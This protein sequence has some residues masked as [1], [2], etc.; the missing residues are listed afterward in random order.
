LLRYSIA[1][2]AWVGA[3]AAWIAS[4]NASP[5]QVQPPDPAPDAAARSL[6]SIECSGCH[7][8]GLEGGQFGPEL[9]GARFL[10]RW[11]NHAAELLKYVSLQMPPNGGGSLSDSEYAGLV[12]LIL[13][14]NGVAIRG[15]G[16]PS[17]PPHASS[18]P[19][20]SSS[21]AAAE[22]TAADPFAD[23]TYLR[24]MSARAKRLA[25]IST[26][27]ARTLRAP[28][29]EDWLSWR[30]TQDAS[31]FSPLQQINKSTISGL[32]LKWAWS[33]K[34]GRNEIAPIVH[35][36]I[37][38]LNSAS[39][40]EALDAANGAFLW[41]YRRD[42]APEYRGPLNMVQRSLAIFGRNLYIATA[43]RHV[44]ALDVGSGNVVWDLEVVTPSESAGAVLSAGP[45]VADGVLVQ[46]VSLGPSCPG[47]CYVVGLDAFTGKLLWRFDTVAKAGP[48]GDTWNGA[49]SAARS[50]SA[51]WT[52]PSYDPRLGAVYV[53]TGNTY[54]ISLLLTPNPEAAATGADALFTDSTLALD[55]KTGK[56]LWYHQHFAQ[57][58]WDL[59]EVFERTL[60][61]LPVGGRPRR[62]MVSVG[63]VGIL[64]ALDRDD[65]RYVFSID[66]GLNNLVTS[67]DP[68]SG[69]RTV[70]RAKLPSKHQPVE[71]CPSV[72]GA[73]NWMATAY[74]P[75]SHILYLPM[76]DVCMDFNWNDTPAAAKARMEMSF[77]M[78]PHPGSDG[79]YGVLEAL[80]LVARKPLWIRRT[81]EVPMSSLLATGG[82]L[83]FAGSSDRSFRGYD[84]RTGKVLWE[85]RLNSPANATPVTFSVAGK[86]YVAIVSG[87]G[88]SHEAASEGLTPELAPSAAA[89]TLW[90]FGL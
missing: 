36:G 53:G 81:R 21:D 32:R 19:P 4:A 10:S 34:P 56:L 18:G 88:G 58:V 86:Q 80:D 43:D 59:D 6:Y 85:T 26:V 8:A 39:D 28:P 66:L 1:S 50:G 14:A 79:R 75:K 47:G 35:D 13:E 16:V 65:G 89:T 61:T 45:L 78:R 25:H 71:V 27:T 84:A 41:R 77:T 72:Q 90:V 3:A 22:H 73:R 82:G 49:P 51:V 40:I 46:G 74:D 63:K 5:G 48:E 60:V 20:A 83:L 33:L 12:A 76:Q 37:I 42:V 11:N 15:E 44:V 30:R 64:D 52:T 57:D 69:R 24:E 38:F 2:V 67:I 70:D 29:A 68:R 7:G 62:L 23:A 31:G 9:E 54:D 55:A 87:G 17:R